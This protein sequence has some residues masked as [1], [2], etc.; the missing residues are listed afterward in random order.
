M[1]LIGSLEGAGVNNELKLNDGALVVNKTSS[2]A[3]QVFSTI[4]SAF[5]M[6]PKAKRIISFSGDGEA[7]LTQVIIL[8]KQDGWVQFQRVGEFR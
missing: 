7:E 4:A 8:Q 5:S 1:N 2:Q 6:G 3:T